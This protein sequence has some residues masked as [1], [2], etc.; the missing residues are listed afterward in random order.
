MK[1]AQALIEFI[2]S[3]Y[4]SKSDFIPLHE[5]NFRGK[6]LD[7]VTNTIR[8]TFVSSVGEYVNRFE[9]DLE[10]YLDCSKVVAVVNGTCGIQVALNAVGVKAGDHVITQAATFVGTANAISHSGAI[11]IFL[12]SD[13]DNLSLSVQALRNFLELKCERRSNEVVF[14][15]TGKKIAACV[16][17]HIFGFSAHIDEIVNLCHEYGIKVIEDAAEGLGTKYKERHLGTFG[18][19]GVFSFNGNKI[20]TTGGGGCIVTNDKDLGDK[21]KHL[22]T[23]AKVPH[24]WDYNHDEIGYNYRMPN[25]NAALGCAQLE[26]LDYYISNKKKVFEAYEQYCNEAG[27]KLYKPDNLHET[28]PN[29]WLNTISLENTETR[30]L[31]LKVLNEAGVMSRPLWILMPELAPYQDCWSDG[32]MNAK[33][34]QAKMINLPSTPIFDLTD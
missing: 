14:K 19:V 27:L 33:L 34:M 25:I 17:V 18:D 15:E 24:A 8:S 26:T 32:A 28:R 4:R 2:R 29:Y 22:T 7:Y 9:S 11:P 3:L 6:E 31:Y 20:I 13:K 12:D 10:K 1:E 21:L 5:P 30:D 16:P 23:T